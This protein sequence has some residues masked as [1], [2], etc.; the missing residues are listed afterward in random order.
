[1]P[2]AAAQHAILSGISDMTRI[3]ILDAIKADGGVVQVTPFT[4]YLRTP[5]DAAQGRATIAEFVNHIDY[6]A[7]RIGWQH[8]GIGTDFDHG[9][10]VDGFD[11]EAEAPNVTR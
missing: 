9:A 2:G 5:A 8:V 10:G 11:S 4:A 6:I 1:M 7:K 3:R